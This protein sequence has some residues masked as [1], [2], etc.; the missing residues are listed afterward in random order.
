MNGQVHSFAAER[1]GPDET[2]SI[3]FTL[4]PRNVGEAQL[5]VGRL[6]S[7]VSVAEGPPPTPTPLPVTADVERADRGS[8]LT[9]GYIVGGVA[10]VLV[11]LIAIA[12]VA[13]SRRR[14]D[15]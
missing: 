6:V 11:G 9:T 8:G 13:G 7:T 3:T 14:G 4:S 10:A 2:R 12:G 1:L 15:S 5:R